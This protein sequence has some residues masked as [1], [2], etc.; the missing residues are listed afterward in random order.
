MFI[1]DFDDTLFDTHAFKHARLD[2]VKEIGVSDELY[3]ETYLVARNTPD[4]LF[5]YSDHRHA[6]VLA[7]H[8]V[9]EETARA[10]L[11]A[12]SAR[13]PEFLQK[14]AHA[15]LQSIKDI[16]LPMVLLSLGD[17][18]YQEFK[19]VASGAHDYF[20]RSFMVDRSKKDVVDELMKTHNDVVWFINDKVTE[21]KEI[22]EKHSQIKT[23]MK[24]SP[25]FE[26]KDYET[27]GMPYF[28]SL[29]EILAYVRK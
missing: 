15:F 26:R 10:T 22:G 20:D 9:D 24:V 1:I 14:D 29:T 16:G 12:V 13:V 5:T 27:C 2:A 19:T 4:G 25:K 8:G 21:S 17:P 11:E 23:V 28:D 6:Q 3:W 18:S 7:Q